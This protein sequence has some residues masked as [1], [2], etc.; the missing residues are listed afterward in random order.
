[1]NGIKLQQK[2]LQQLVQGMSVCVALNGAW[3]NLFAADPTMQ[4]LRRACRHAE[5]FPTLAQ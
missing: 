1:M 2:M 4:M 5:L 3:H